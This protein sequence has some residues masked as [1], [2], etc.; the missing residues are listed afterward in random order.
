MSDDVNFLNIKVPRWALILIW[1]GLVASG[2]VVLLILLVII[3]V[4]FK[5]SEKLG[6]L[7]DWFGAIGTIG[8]VGFALFQHKVIMERDKDEYYRSVHPQI[9]I[10][11]GHSFEHVGESSLRPVE[12]LDNNGEKE[13]TSLSKSDVL[14][15]KIS[16]LLAN[17]AVLMKIIVTYKSGFQSIYGID[18]L[19]ES[20]RNVILFTGTSYANYEAMGVNSIK[21]FLLTSRRERI[22]SRF[23]WDEELDGFIYDE[24]NSFTEHLKGRDYADSICKKNNYNYN[25]L[26]ISKIEVIE[27]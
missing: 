22:F 16:N 3:F 15:F 1:T 8:A 5:Y 19:D 4:I 13:T 11:V 26:K 9:K 18:R 2:I 6:T 27:E 10:D 17:P 24:E 21:I 20:K 7:A 23:L 14:I 25:T 12:R